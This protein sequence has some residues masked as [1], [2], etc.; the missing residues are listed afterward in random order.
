[1]SLKQQTI[2]GTFWSAIEKIS[3]LG[4]QFV[5][6][7][8]LARLLTPTDYGV[9]GILAVFL[10]LANTFIDCGF[11]SALIQNQKRTEIDF[12]TAFY[13]NVC[14]ASGFYFLLCI[15]APY[16]ASFYKLPVLLPVTRVLA[17]SLPIASLAAIHRVKLQ[18]KVDFKTQTI[19]TLL[20]VILS[21]VIGIFLAYKGFGVWAL[22]IQ[23]VLNAVFNVLCL[24]C[25]VK[26]WPLFVFS[27]DSFKMMF[28]FGVKLLAS[29]LLDT[30]YFN[31]YPL[32]I[33]KVFS[34]A[35]LGLYSRASQFANLTSNLSTSI[36]SRVSFP[37]LSQIQD[38]KEKLF[39]VY[40]R[41]LAIIAA[42]YAPIILGICAVAKPMILLLLGAR[43]QGV[44]IL[45][46][47]LCVACMFDCI[48]NINI[49]LLYV[50]GY[51]HL[52]LKLNIIK[53][54]IAFCILILF[55][56]GG[57]VGLCIGQ[58][59][60]AQIAVFL[61]TYYTKKILGFSYADQM[62][63]VFPIYLVAAIAALVAYFAT[64]L[65]LSN[66]G[67]LIVGVSCAGGLYIWLAYLFKFEIWQ[68]SFWLVRKLIAS[69]S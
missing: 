61:N 19:A 41:Y 2:Q 10:A 54:I 3:F 30:L 65:P 33:G 21:G 58:I 51:T 36:V 45:L 20:A 7:V 16:I 6:Q 63:D 39:V 35:A 9:V 53:K 69:Q 43:W 56:R 27:I 55:L 66:Y 13:F 12:S 25:L 38:N 29:N 37:I 48:T 44:I 5:L 42:I 11:T 57:V 59:I 14:I 22:V 18:I 28:N 40:R 8:I 17:L 60:Y 47:I 26:W 67:Q 52:V 31:M 62:R 50:K 4:I 34:P 32:I 49:N 46:R 15:A 1:M 24:F 23:H 68:E 64:C